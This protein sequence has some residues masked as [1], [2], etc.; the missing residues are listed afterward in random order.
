MAKK[1]TLTKEQIERNDL[2][3]YFASISSVPVNY[4]A[5]NSMLKKIMDTGRYTYNGLKYALWYG[6]VHQG[7]DITSIAI[8][9]Y[10]YDDAK[11][12]YNWLKNIKKQVSIWE[13]EEEEIVISKKRDREEDVFV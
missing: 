9:E 6:K 2:I 12:Y 5:T 4:A 1:K 7:L 10:L 8:S 13:K 11:K 3:A